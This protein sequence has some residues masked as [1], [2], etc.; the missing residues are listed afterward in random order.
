MKDRIRIVAL[1]GLDADGKNLYCVEINDAIFIIGCGLGY[2][3]KSTP[4]V[5]YIIS[6]ISYLR[7]NKDR[8]KAYIIQDSRDTFMFGI[9]FIYQEIPAPIYMSEFAKDILISFSK[10]FS[11]YNE[12]KYTIICVDPNK[13]IEIAGIK[14]SFFSIASGI[15]FTFGIAIDTTEGNIIFSGDFIIEYN[16][17]KGFNFNVNKLTRIVNEKPT[18]MLLADSNNAA[19]KGFTS[20]SHRSEDIIRKALN[21]AEARTYIAVYS[22]NIYGLCEALNNC[23][24]FGKYII[25]FDEESRG[26]YSLLEKYNLVKIPASRIIPIEQINHHPERDIAIIICGQ[27][28]I[29]YNKI[30]MLAL[31][32][33]TESRFYIKEKD[34]FILNCPPAPNFEVLAVSV[35]DELYKT[36]CKVKHISR[37]NLSKIHPSEDDLK[38]FISIVNPRYY[39]PIEGQF[40]DL[41]ANATVALGMNIGLNHSS[42]FLLD[43]GQSINYQDEKPYIVPIETENTKVRVGPILV[44]GSGIGDVANEII[45]ERNS[46]AEDGVIVMSCLISL[47][48]KAIIGGPDIQ[49][50]GYLFLK[51][52]EQVLKKIQNLFLDIVNNHLNDE[53]IPFN[54]ERCVKEV[55]DSCTKFTRKNTARTPLIEPH[56]LIID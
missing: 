16:K 35:L 13:D 47:S 19:R 25:F 37:K 31:K 34:T 14:F 20:P 22:Q 52:S 28:E 9:P 44:D 26:I 36:D 29:L 10:K 51:E 32:D 45:S 1:G 41:M 2:P 4:G 53:T 43:N 55:K 49:M 46:L 33:I 24:N 30:S 8:V 11:N 5:D 56:V 6:D 15:P 48:Q 17:T 42:I 3:D 50:R 40:K 54:E 27:G 12:L 38:F 23:L 21:E 18:F 7:E 39:V